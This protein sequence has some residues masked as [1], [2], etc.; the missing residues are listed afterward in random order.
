MRTRFKRGA[1]LV[2]AITGLVAAGHG[3]GLMSQARAE[4]FK[5]GTYNIHIAGIFSNGGWGIDDWIET[6]R[7]LVLDAIEANQPDIMGFQEAFARPN[8]FGTTTQQT[9]LGEIFDGTKYRFYT[10]EVASQYNATPSENNWNPIIVNTQRFT[11]VAAGSRTVNFQTYL[12]DDTW[13]DYFRL[14]EVF[15]DDDPND[16]EFSAHSLTPQ[17]YVNWV[18]SEDQRTGGKVAFLT[19]HYETFIGVNRYTPTDMNDEFGK[20]YG[21]LFDDFSDLV[22]D[23]FG[24]AS[25]EIHAQA[26]HLRALHGDN[27]G[28]VIG[29]DF[30]TR[31]PTLPAQL[32]FTEAGYEETYRYTHP[33][34]N[35]PRPTQGI[36]VMWAKTG[37]FAIDASDYDRLDYTNL[38]GSI[39]A[40]DHKPL[41][42]VLTQF[43]NSLPADLT[44]NGFVDFQDLTILLAN[45]N[46][47]V[48][49]SE[50]NLV[51]ADTTPVNF[52]DLTVLL[53]DWTGPGPAGSPEAVLGEAVPEPSTL[54]LAI[55]GLLVLGGVWRR[56]RR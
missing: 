47:E 56:G 1:V 13:D 15:H 26:E 29:G 45:W 2:A 44:N 23:S 54:L 28:V 25:R 9:A 30:E 39:R 35:M 42:T 24:F 50:G 17:R 32:A 18:V 21:D 16:G 4:G 52:Q 31:D 5:A 19:S 55:G 11:H 14:H 46:K 40:S 3:L 41:F 20:T 7:W 43:V 48:T 51:N 37:D 12:G 22:N 53:A 8:R 38:D 33:N 6:R 49:A 10:W 27:L 34:S 36:D